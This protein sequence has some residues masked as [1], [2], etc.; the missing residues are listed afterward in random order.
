MESRTAART[1]AVLWPAALVATTIAHLATATET[2]R[3]AADREPSHAK[4]LS[5]EFR[6]AAQRVMPSVVLIES[7]RGPRAT[8]QWRRLQQ[9]R[10][11]HLTRSEVLTEDDPSNPRDERGSGIIIDGSGVILTCHHV[12]AGADVIFVTLSDGRRFEPIDV[13]SEPDRDLAILRINT[14]GQLPAA[15][16]GDS[17]G[18]QLGDWVVSVGNPYGLERSISTGTV[19]ATDRD[20]SLSPAPLIQ[21]DAS[22]NPG[23]SGGALANL[24]GEVVGVLAGSLGVDAG[25]QGVSLAVPINGARQVAEELSKRGTRVHGYLGC[26]LQPLSP[27]TSQKLE[28]PRE[29]GLYVLYVAEETPAARAKLLVGD[30]IT[31]FDGEPIDEQHPFKKI[32]DDVEPGEAHRLL[33][34]REG[35]TRHISITIDRRPGANSLTPPHP[36]EHKHVPSQPFCKRFGLCV[37]ALLPEVA[38]QL[39]YDA[40]ATGALIAG[41]ETGGAAYK[42]GIAA[43]MLVLRVNEHEIRTSADFARVTSMVPPEKPVLMLIKS[44]DKRY[45][46][47]LANQ[48]TR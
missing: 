31:H 13:R 4:E 19:S 11:R 23:S 41:V 48:E 18:L 47:I 42:D 7:L 45:L 26:D 40:D 24:E 44:P 15:R 36:P 38:S 22:S 27:R 21:S 6:A 32:F 9:R 2:Q 3:Q 30:L 20:T 25:F 16:L 29:G 46:T 43:G 39:G 34:F 17:D 14:D 28:L 37:D 33:V 35:R 12:V 1:I 5:Q 10:N 8:P